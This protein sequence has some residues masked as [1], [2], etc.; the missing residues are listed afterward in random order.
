MSSPLTKWSSDVTSNGASLRMTTG[1]PL[2]GFGAHQ[3]FSALALNGWTSCSKEND[4]IT[5]RR[6]TL[7]STVLGH[8]SAVQRQC[9]ERFL[10]CSAASTV[11]V[12]VKN[13]SNFIAR[14]LLQQSVLRG[15]SASWMPTD[16]LPPPP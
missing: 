5:K 4:N 12:L 10:D 11:C 7:H 3:A 16:L 13:V 8:N 15:A 2:S 1:H 14:S 9:S 6:G